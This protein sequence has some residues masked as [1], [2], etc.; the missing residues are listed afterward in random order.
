MVDSGASMHM[1]STKDLSSEEMDTL[2]RS[3]YPTV[4]MTVNGEVQTF[5]KHKNC[6]RSWLIRDCAV[7]R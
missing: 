1:L 4:D 2:K 3:R 6:S 7:T 5:E